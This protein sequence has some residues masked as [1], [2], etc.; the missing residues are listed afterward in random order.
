MKGLSFCQLDAI[1]SGGEAIAPPVGFSRGI[2]LGFSDYYRCPR[3]SARWSATVWKGKH[4]AADGTFVNQFAGMKA[5][6]S[7]IACGPSWYDG[8]E[9]VILEYPKGTPVFDD[10]RD[11]VRRVGPDVYLSRLYNRYRCEFR[12]YIVLHPECR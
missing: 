4:F 6:Q 9:C 5:L 11:E 3:A 12:G 7:T 10:M 1:F 2:I 8:K